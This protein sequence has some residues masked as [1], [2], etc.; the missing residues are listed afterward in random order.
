MNVY[1]H[2][3]KDRIPGGWLAVYLLLLSLVIFLNTAC[4]APEDPVEKTIRPVRVILAS[5]EEHEE[6][7]M[8]T[9]EVLPGETRHISFLVSGRIDELFVEKEEVIN[10]DTVLGTVDDLDYQRALQ[11][12]RANFQAAQANLDKAV[13]GA[14]QEELL[15]MEL[16]LKKARE[17][18]EYANQ[19]LD[20]LENLYQAGGISQADLDRTTMETAAAE[21]S[22]Q[23]AE[24]QYQQL[25]NGTRPEDIS[26]LAALRD[27]AGAEVSHFDTQVERTTLYASHNG[28]VAELFYQQGEIYRQGTPFLTLNSH[29]NIVRVSVSRQQLAHVNTG[30]SVNVLHDEGGIEGVITMVSSNP[31]PLTRTY[32]VEVELPAPSLTLG[33]LVQVEFTTKGAL[34]TPL[35]MKAVLAGNPDYVYVIEKETAKQVPVNLQ[36]LDGSTIW[37]TGLY[38]GQ[39]VVVEGMHLLSHGETVRVV[40][41]G[42]SP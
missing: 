35:P 11:G 30:D 19:Q 18:Y 4:T 42:D 36:Q 29:D 28:T 1:L 16:Q 21:A 40:E 17:A 12:A 37:V 15:E 23:Q 26:A 22:Y 41:I 14:T 2:R 32:R 10:P 3:G 24:A 39:H 7:I 34:G 5:L 13:A 33:E 9:G 20:R 31:D 8:M 27:A 6:T 25:V 38:E